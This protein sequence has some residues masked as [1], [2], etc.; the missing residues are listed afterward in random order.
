MVQHIPL[1]KTLRSSKTLQ[2]RCYHYPHFTARETEAAEKCHQVCQLKW[3]YD[4]VTMQPAKSQN[5]V[6]IPI[7]HSWQLQHT[8]GLS[9]TN[10]TLP[11]KQKKQ[12]LRSMQRC[13]HVSKP[14]HAQP[15]GHHPLLRHTENLLSGPSLGTEL[16]IMPFALTFSPL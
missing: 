13:T 7:P 2:S 9:E 6:L 12:S 1:C 15:P 14:L 4:Q 11:I 10:L 16:N 8:L 5:W 3:S